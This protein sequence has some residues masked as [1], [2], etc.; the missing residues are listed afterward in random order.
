MNHIQKQFYQKE[1]IVAKEDRFR[2]C[3]LHSCLI[4]CDFDIRKPRKHGPKVWIT[5]IEEIYS[6][7]FLSVFDKC[8][9]Q[10]CV[11]ETAPQEY[12]GE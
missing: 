3:K 8:D 9:I 7:Q 4:V 12:N 6:K 2:G 11:L 10:F 5:P 1:L